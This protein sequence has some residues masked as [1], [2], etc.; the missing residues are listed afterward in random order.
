QEAKRKLAR[1]AWGNHRQLT[2]CWV[3]EVGDSR[4]D[5]YHVFIAFKH[6]YRRTG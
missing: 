6:L 1:C 3:R 2:Y 4:K 5:H